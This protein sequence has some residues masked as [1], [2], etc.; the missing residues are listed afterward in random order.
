MNRAAKIL[1][2][3]LILVLSGCGSSF[4]SLY[5]SNYPLTS[6]RI[7]SRAGTLSVKVPE[8][9]FAAEDNEKN[10]FD[11]WLVKNDYSASMSLVPLNIDEK[12]SEEISISGVEGLLQI[13][14]SFRKLESS[15]GYAETLSS[16]FFEYNGI[17]Y[18]SYQYLKNNNLKERVIIFLYHRVPYE[19]TVSCEISEMCDD[20]FMHELFIIQNAVLLSIK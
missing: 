8:E 14:K 7:F 5:E 4:N 1:L 2:L 12:I 9:W 19:L 13:S 10:I 16:E 11:I 18:A 20:Q 17:E 6:H 3:I 15:F